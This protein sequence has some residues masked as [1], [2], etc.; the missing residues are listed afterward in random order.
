[1]CV[2]NLDKKLLCLVCN[3]EGSQKNILQL[4][5]KQT[6]T[7]QELKWEQHPHEAVPASLLLSVLYT[8]LKTSAVLKQ[9]SSLACLHARIEGRFWLTTVQTQCMASQIT[10]MEAA[11]FSCEK[12]FWAVWNESPGG[13]H[14]HYPTT[15]K[16]LILIS[17]S[18]LAEKYHFC[19]SVLCSVAWFHAGRIYPFRNVVK[20]LFLVLFFSVLWNGKLP[21]PSISS[22][23]ALFL[24][25]SWTFL[26]FLFQKK[27]T[28]LVS[29]SPSS[30][31]CL[32]VSLFSFLFLFFGF[33]SLHVIFI[34]RTIKI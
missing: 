18:F 4:R 26:L 31:E 21:A 27:S 8:D 29:S 6:K 1:M 12:C 16:R 14:S 24:C 7:R 22:L 25:I 30:K 28:G 20:Q 3:R 34:E 23:W 10:C 9:T 33:F 32:T 5:E 2:K 13:I 19:T 17:N 15:C 11:H